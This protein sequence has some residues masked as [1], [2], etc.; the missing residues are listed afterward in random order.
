[1]GGDRLWIGDHLVLEA[2]VELHVPGLVDLL[3]G[4]KGDFLLAAAR[5]HEARELRRDPLL[6]DHQRA[7]HEGDERAVL[8]RRPLFAVNG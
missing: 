5:P 2:C 1:M 4:E 7:Q 6:G 8:H 3:R